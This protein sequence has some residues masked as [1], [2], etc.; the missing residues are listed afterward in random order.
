[1]INDIDD[2]QDKL[3]DEDVDKLIK[4]L[5]DELENEDLDQLIKGTEDEIMNAWKEYESKSIP[6]P[7]PPPAPW[8]FNTY[9]REPQNYNVEWNNNQAY[10]DQSQQHKGGMDL[11]QK[12]GVC[13]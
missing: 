3:K 12:D 5:E 7:P 10:I 13:S 11:R 4:D 9:T 2:N 8:Q 1:M 6:P